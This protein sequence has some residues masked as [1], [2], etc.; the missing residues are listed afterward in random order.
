M[1]EIAKVLGPNG[2]LW[3]SA[4]DETWRLRDDWPAPNVL[5][6]ACWASRHPEPTE[7]GYGVVYLIFK[8]PDGMSRWAN[9]SGHELVFNPDFWKP[10]APDS[11]G[12]GSE[13]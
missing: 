2:E 4:P 8:T 10:R 1:S 13:R 6:D 9:E 11:A 7:Y 3:A 5:V 12:N